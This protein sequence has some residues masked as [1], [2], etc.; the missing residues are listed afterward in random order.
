M[1]KKFC[2]I[3]SGIVIIS[4]AFLL[5]VYGAIFC[6]SLFSL[7]SP[8]LKTFVSTPLMNVLNPSSIHGYLRSLEPT[9]I[10]NQL[11]PNS[12]LVTPHKPPA[13][14]FHEQKTI[15][16]YS[17]PPTTPATLVAEG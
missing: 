3:T 17:I 5:N 4:S 6:R 12:W 15:P 9:I 14:L 8:W 13:L 11:W 1:P 10:G 2:C 16:G 7:N